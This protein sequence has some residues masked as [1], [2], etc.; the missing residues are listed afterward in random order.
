MP[1]LFAETIFVKIE[2]ASSAGSTAGHV[3]TVG[4]AFAVGKA[5]LSG[6]MAAPVRVAVR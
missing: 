1:F 2:R 3:G 5:G 4:N 6:M